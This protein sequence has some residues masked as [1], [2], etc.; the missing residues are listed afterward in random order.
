MNLSSFAYSS[1]K[2]PPQTQKNRLKNMKKRYPLA[3]PGSP[4]IHGRLPSA[5]KVKTQETWHVLWLNWIRLKQSNKTEDGLW[6]SWSP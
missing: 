3:Y 4:S 1:M 6:R 2:Y 5:T